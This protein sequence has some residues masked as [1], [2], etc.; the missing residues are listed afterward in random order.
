[1]KTLKIIFKACYTVE[2]LYNTILYDTQ[3]VESKQSLLQLKKNSP[4]YYYRNIN[5][6]YSKKIGKFKQS[7]K[8]S[9]EKHCLKVHEIIQEK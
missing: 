3:L 9:L 6:L 1:M 5:T 7:I 4:F 8:F 2:D